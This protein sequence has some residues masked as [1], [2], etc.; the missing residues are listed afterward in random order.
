MQ[1]QIRSRSRVA[2]H[3]LVP[4]F[5]MRITASRG[6]QHLT[7]RGFQRPLREGESVSIP[8][9]ESVDLQLTGAIFSPSECRLELDGFTV[10]TATRQ[11]HAQVHDMESRILYLRELISGSVFQ[12]PQKIWNADIVA[13]ALQTTPDK[14][15]SALFTQGAAFTQLCRTQRLMRAFFESFQFNLTVADLKARVGW[16]DAGDLEASFLDWFGVSLQTISRLREDCL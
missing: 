3:R 5:P 2:L 15:R 9:F 13:D 14:I 6:E 11:I 10:D 1:V 12:E 16:S 7:R 4:A 8:A